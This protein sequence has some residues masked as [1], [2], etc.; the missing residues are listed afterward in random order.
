LAGTTH[1]DVGLL[2][3]WMCPKCDLWSWRK[4]NKDRSFHASNWLFDQTTHV[5]IGP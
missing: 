3:V 1:N 4:G 5:D 2:S